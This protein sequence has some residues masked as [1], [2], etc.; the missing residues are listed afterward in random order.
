MSITISTIAINVFTVGSWVKV[1][2]MIP[3]IEVVIIFS[4][5]VISVI[6]VYL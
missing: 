6:T 2:R 4:I 5:R 1:P 3:F